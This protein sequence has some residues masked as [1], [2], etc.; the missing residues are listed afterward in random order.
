MNDQQTFKMILAAI[1][2]VAPG[3]AVHAKGMD[4]T[5]HDL[6]IDSVATMELVSSLEESVGSSIPDEELAR[7]RRIGDL[8]TLVATAQ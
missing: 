6:E 1:D 7:V 2:E 3:H 4:T 8:A 5:I